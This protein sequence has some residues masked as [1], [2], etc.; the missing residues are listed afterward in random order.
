VA[1]LKEHP[2]CA[3]GKVSTQVLIDQRNT[4]MGYYCEGCGAQALKRLTAQEERRDR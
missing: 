3:C 4:L 2:P 1:W